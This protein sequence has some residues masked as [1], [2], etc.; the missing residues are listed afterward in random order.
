MSTARRRTR[1]GEAI[2]AVIREAGRPLA[3]AEILEF[4][5]SRVTSLSQATVYRQVRR[6]LEAGA[7][8][9]IVL[10]GSPARYEDATGGR[11]VDA[12][13][14]DVPPARPVTGRGAA[15]ASGAH[16]HFFHC[17]RCDAVFPV[18]GCAG[19][20]EQLAPPAFHVR[21]H[22]VVL[23]GECAACVDKAGDDQAGHDA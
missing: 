20:V 21:R 3:P 12:D 23:Y 13:A 5:T 18:E 16:H 4:A 14:S 6:L 15:A 19:D 1:Q 10:P 2:H 11:E 22:E 17:E 8:R 7:I 9:E